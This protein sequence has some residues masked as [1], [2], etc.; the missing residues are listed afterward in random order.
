[1]LHGSAR[2]DD[3]DG[4]DGDDDCR[5]WTRSRGTFGTRRARGTCASRAGWRAVTTGLMEK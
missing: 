1:M 4:Y 3:E 5:C 2:E